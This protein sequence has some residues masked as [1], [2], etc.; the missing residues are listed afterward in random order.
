MRWLVLGAL[1]G[2]LLLYPSLLAVIAAAVAWLVS[3]PV[4]VAFALGLAAR[5][6]LPRMRRWAR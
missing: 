1:L 3:K 6:H 2:L 4:I 5:P